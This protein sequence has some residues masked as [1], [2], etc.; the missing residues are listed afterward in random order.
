MVLGMEEAGDIIVDLPETM[1]SSSGCLSL[2]Y[3]SRSTEDL[4]ISVFSS[5]SLQSLSCAYFLRITVGQYQAVILASSFVK[6]K[7]FYYLLSLDYYVSI[8]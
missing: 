3:Q 6:R 2:R 5:A 8:L 7:S 4:P 1:V